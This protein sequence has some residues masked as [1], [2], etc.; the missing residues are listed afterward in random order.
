MSTNNQKPTISINDA[1]TYWS[2]TRVPIVN[3]IAMNAETEM[4]KAFIVL[5]MAVVANYGPLVR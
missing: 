3:E 5:F 2:C 4:L 1:D